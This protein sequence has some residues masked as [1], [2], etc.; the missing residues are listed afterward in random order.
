MISV[1][2]V[3]TGNICRSPTA[4]GVFQTLVNEC[5]LADDIQVDSA[6]THDWHKGNPPDPRSTEAAA[7]RG[8]DLS[9]QR[10]RPITAADFS[11]FDYILAMDVDNYDILRAQYPAGAKSR[12]EYF[13]DFAPD[14]D[15]QEV[16]DPYYG[17]ARGFEDVLDMIETASLGLL[18]DI[19]NRHLTVTT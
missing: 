19:Q 18:A 2:F 16:P 8:V 17:G 13:L 10:S 4:E 14:I 12:L 7:R 3:C 15:L 1:L 6:G 9:R 5:T 11:T